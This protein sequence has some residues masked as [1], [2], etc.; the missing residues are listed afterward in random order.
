M[1]VKQGHIKSSD[2]YLEY[3]RPLLDTLDKVGLGF[4]IGPICI[5]Y[6]DIALLIMSILSVRVK[7]DFRRHSTYHHI[8]ES[9]IGSLLVLQ[10]LKLPYLDLKLTDSST[11]TP[12]LGIWMGQLLIYQT[13]MITWESL[14]VE[15]EVRE[16][17]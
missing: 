11:K 14:L 8:M 3:N 12:N 17:M 5:N 2:H 7:K 13:Q 4:W 15:K 10:K 9:A 16:K 6:T 1:G